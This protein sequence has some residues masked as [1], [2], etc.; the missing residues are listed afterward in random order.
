M[1]AAPVHESLGGKEYRL[2]D[3]TRRLSIPSK[4]RFRYGSTVYLLRN[5]Q[6]E[7]EECIVVY[8][9]EDYL[10]VYDGLAKSYDGAELTFMQR[11]FSQN[12]SMA[13]IDKAGRVSIPEDFLS[14]AELNEVPGAL[15]VCH[16]DRLELWN[17]GKWNK[18]FDVPVKP[19]FSRFNIS[20]RG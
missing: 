3:Q 2:F 1:P 12:I 5:F 11:F 7:G 4:F 13:S 6:A 19:D 14:Y 9:E 8:N 17:E 20:P 16:P 10:K 15:L 18:L